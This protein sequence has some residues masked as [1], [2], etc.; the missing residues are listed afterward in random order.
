MSLTSAE[1][2]LFN[3]LSQGYSANIEQHFHA[4]RVDVAMTSPKK[5]GYSTVAYR[6][7]FVLSVLPLAVWKALSVSHFRTV[8]SHFNLSTLIEERKSMI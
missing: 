1:C 6:L 4:V 2:F 3:M 5:A 7:R 8:M